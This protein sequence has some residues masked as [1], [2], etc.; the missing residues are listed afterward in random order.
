MATVAI[1]VAFGSG[2]AFAGASAAVTLLATAAATYVD[3]ALLM[4]ALTKQ[5]SA[6]LGDIT[7]TRGDEGAPHSFGVSVYNRMPG[8][9]AWAPR[10]FEV[11]STDVGKGGPS[12]TNNT[13]YSHAFWIYARTIGV[14]VHR[15]ATAWLNGRRRYNA[16]SEFIRATFAFGQQDISVTR[17]MPTQFH[18][19]TYIEIATLDAS[20]FDLREFSP[21]QLIQVFGMADAH[22]NG[23]YRIRA[24]GRFNDGRTWMRYHNE[25]GTTV[26]VEGSAAVPD[27]S[28]NAHVFV[29]ERP[30]HSAGLVDWVSHRKGDRAHAV[31]PEIEAEEG[32]GA[33]PHYNS[34]AGH[35][36]K[37]LKLSDFGNR[38]PSIEAQVEFSSEVQ[39]ISEGIREILQRYFE[40]GAS[41]MDTTLLDDEPD[42]LY[43]YWWVA[44]YDSQILQ[45]IIIAYDLVMAEIG[46]KLHIYKRQDAPV[47]E[48]DPADLGAHESGSDNFFPLDVFDDDDG[49]FPGYVSVTFRD[50]DAEM[51]ESNVQVRRPDFVNNPKID[52]NFENLAMTS[53]MAR[54]IAN[55]LLFEKASSRQE[56]EIALPPRYAHITEGCYLTFTVSGKTWRMFVK[57]VR[58]G[59]QGIRLCS[60]YSDPEITRN[61]PGIAIEAG[62]HLN[63]GQVETYHPPIPLAYVLDIPP[64]DDT[65]ALEPHLLLGGSAYYYTSVWQGAS[66]FAQAPFATGY[67]QIGDLPVET[68]SGRLTT[69][70]PDGTPGF[71][72]TDGEL[73]VELYHGE[74]HTVNED[75]QLAGFNICYLN[76]ELFSFQNATISTDPNDRDNVYIIDTFVRGLRGTERHIQA[77]PV[78]S[79]FIFVRLASMIVRSQSLGS[80]GQTYLHKLV[81]DQG[82]LDDFEE[83]ET[84]VE[85]NSIRPFE[86][87]HVTG[88]ELSGTA[89]ITWQ[90]RSRLVIP[91]FASPAGPY[92]ETEEE[93]IVHIYPGLD[94]SGTPIRTVN[95]TTPRFIYTS[96]MRITDGNDGI[97]FIVSVISVGASLNSEPATVTLPNVT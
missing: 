69:V 10:E 14:P 44:P 50:I 40:I 15:M 41:E 26:G 57:T 18:S 86:V 46:G 4:P 65:Q 88:Y 93:Y 64:L 8:F 85:G 55:R 81:P 19:S 9:L 52:M 97:D 77:H 11:V 73:R 74:L 2:G 36:W 82:Q 96:A 42:L 1:A 17:H 84:V 48:V 23:T 53:E 12:A 78:D 67:S 59:D 43:G 60:G 87:A 61:L 21:G 39:T 7:I 31:L 83:V 22:N 90:R 35:H 27:G 80:L 38:L 58:R 51:T 28:L 68:V 32:V 34:Y 92:A 24:V 45:P 25:D 95:V 16:T 91:C 66:F 94:M 13:Y 63:G 33:V 37:R 30:A 79:V 70:M 20:F 75:Q 76:G 56:L 5:P 72:N 3:Q 89:I 29:Q 62:G 49:Q 71:I 47:Y 54:N 6:K